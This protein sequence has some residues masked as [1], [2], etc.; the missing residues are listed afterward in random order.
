VLEKAPKPNPLL[1]KERFIQ[2]TTLLKN[3]AITVNF[4]PK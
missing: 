4:L 2:L 3:L 1:L